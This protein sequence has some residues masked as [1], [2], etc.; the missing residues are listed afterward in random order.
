MT[1][2]SILSFHTQHNDSNAKH[3]FCSIERDII[4]FNP[5]FLSDIFWFLYTNQNDFFGNIKMICSYF[6][7]HHCTKR[8]YTDVLNLSSAVIW[9]V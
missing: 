1:V 4:K 3:Q 5:G 2:G 8:L 9:C 7:E 6:I